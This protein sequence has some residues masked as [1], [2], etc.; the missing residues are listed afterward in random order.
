MRVGFVTLIGR[1]NVGKSSLL[2]A[3]LNYKVAITSDK[4]QTT[5]DQIKGIYNDE[6]SQIIFI[7]TPGIHKPKQLLGESLND[8]SYSAIKDVDIALF[9]QPADEEIGPGDRKVIE[10]LG[11]VNRVAVISK[12]DRVT[13]PDVI[14]KVK[15]LKDLG[16]TD[17]I[18]T[19]TDI[20]PSINAIIEYLKEKLPEGPAMYDREQV[21]DRSMR[22][23]AKEVIR[24]SAINFTKH[25][26]P[27]SIGV[28]I[29]DFDEHKITDKYYI[30]A[31]I[32]VERDSQKGILV[33]K[34]G[35]MIKKIGMSARKKIAY[36]FNH[37]IHLELRVKVKKN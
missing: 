32:F 13:E 31:T 17:V 1:P 5:R 35:A 28:M 33:G 37:K 27:H 34:Q 22:F 29:E 21:T 36:T 2:N 25:E 18:A 30:E 9:L 10:K 15:Q 23:L 14:E 7:D 8:K 26:I 6:D 3:I 12:I 4:P 24:E 19:S 11:K 16:F 20:R